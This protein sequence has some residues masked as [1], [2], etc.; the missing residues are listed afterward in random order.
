MDIRQRTAALVA[1]LAAAGALAAGCSSLPGAGDPSEDSGSAGTGTAGRAGSDVPAGRPAVDATAAPVASGTFDTPLVAG[2]K[3]DIA[4][5][6]L[7]ARGRL[8][9]LTIRITPHLPANHS[10]QSP[11]PYELNG[12]NRPGASL[13][14]PV[15]LKRYVVVKDSSGSEMQSN[16]LSTDINNNQPAILTY[17]FAAPPENVK[18]VDVQFGS[19][20]T[21]RTIPVKR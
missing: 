3:V 12:N 8:A 19:W 6:D 13:I 9:T 17:T 7:R 16:E 20:P 21:F 2:G 14:D 18:A 11:T 15:N 5:M 4:V 1:A 10:D